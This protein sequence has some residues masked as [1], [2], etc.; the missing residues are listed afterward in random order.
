M[1]SVVDDRLQEQYQRLGKIL[2]DGDHAGLVHEFAD[3]LIRVPSGP[4]GRSMTQVY[5]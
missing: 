1:P 5:L 4:S 2:A 3:G